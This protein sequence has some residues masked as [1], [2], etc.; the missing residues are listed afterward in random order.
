[1]ER[2]K[3]LTKDKLGFSGMLKEA[4]KILFKTPKFVALS[5][6]TSLPL[7]CCM[8]IHE[9]WLQKTLIDAA[10]FMSPSQEQLEFRDVIS[11]RFYQQIDPPR[12][13]A[14][15]IEQYGP[16]FLQLGLLYLPLIH[17]PDL[18]NTVGVVSSASAMYS[19]EK[20]VDLKET[21]GRSAFRRSLI[22]SIYVLL[23]ASMVFLGLLAIASQVYLLSSDGRLTWPSSIYVLLFI[24]LLYK[25]VQWRSLWNLG[26]VTSILEEKHGY[27]ALGVSAYVSRGNRRHGEAVSAMLFVWKVSLR[28]MATAYVA[29]HEGD[30]MRAVLVTALQVF[31]VC[32]GNVVKWVFFMIFF[33]DCKIRFLE[34]K[35]DVEEG[36]G[37]ASVKTVT[38]S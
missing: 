11:I 32:S 7:F 25:Y 20:L 4:L 31:L 36:E 10:K 38:A 21:F 16:A 8:L 34:K 30:Q 2:N 29:F 6:M 24:A 13:M 1:M 27:V 37:E 35:V 22:T 19:D 12:K 14:Q 5:F 26:L 3:I 17:L 15:F 28:L 23:M 33:C 18:V 9:L